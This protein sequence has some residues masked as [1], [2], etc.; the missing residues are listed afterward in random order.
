MLNAL[1][2]LSL[3]FLLG[4][5]HATDPDHIIAVSTIVSRERSLG[6]AARIGTLWGLGHTATIVAIGAP[7][8][9]LRWRISPAIGA[10]MELGVALMLII[11][12]IASLIDVR[13]GGGAKPSHSHLHQH[14]DR[15]HRHPHGHAPAAAHDDPAHDD[16]AHGHAAD[17]TALGVLDRLAGRARAYGLIRPVVVGVVHGLAGSAAITLLVL[18]T[19][20]TPI[21]AVAYLLIFGAG[22]I[23]G[24]VLLTTAIAVPVVA[25]GNR[26][27]AGNRTLRVAF[28]VLSIGFGIVLAVQNGLPLAR[29]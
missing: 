24:M 18:S 15:I 10:A 11:L 19:I 16:P 9:L 2:I 14:G 23:L 8:I 25:T 17:A 27:L 5:R 4:I 26:S 22:T 12:G 29:M 6:R 7:L 21:L 28:A 1:V 3:G 13:H 20:R